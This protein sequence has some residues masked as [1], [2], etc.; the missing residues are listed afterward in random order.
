MHIRE[1]IG[2][3]D[4]ILEE[5]N[6]HLDDEYSNVRPARSPGASRASPSPHPT[7]MGPRPSPANQ[8]PPGPPQAVLALT[9]APPWVGGSGVG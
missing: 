2:Y 3:P 6:K 8:E 4:Y 7:P 9:W 1:Q 5:R